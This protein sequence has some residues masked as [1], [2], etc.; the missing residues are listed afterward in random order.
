M[1][2]SFFALTGSI[3]V[4]SLVAGC[5]HAQAS[6]KTTAGMPTAIAK[7]IEDCHVPGKWRLTSPPRK[8][9]IW[10]YHTESGVVLTWIRATQELTFEGP[11]PEATKFETAFWANRV[12]LCETRLN[13]MLCCLRKGRERLEE[14]DAESSGQS[15]QT[16]QGV[17]RSDADDS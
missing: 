2:K 13:H 8:P 7:T 16:Q 3:I 11:E 15:D 17:A 5:A 9:D 4:A 6:T 10:H 1:S 12:D 14:L